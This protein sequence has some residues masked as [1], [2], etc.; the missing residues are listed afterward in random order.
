MKLYLI[1]LS[2]QGDF[3]GANL[4]QALKQKSSQLEF[5]G[6]G[7]PKMGLKKVIPYEKLHDT[8]YSTENEKKFLD[9]D[10]DVVQDILLQKPDVLITIGNWDF[11]KGLYEKLSHHK[12]LF[13]NLIKVHY[14]APRIF[15]HNN[16]IAAT[17][18][19]YID[20]LI[21]V[22][23]QE[24]SCFSTY[25]LPAVY[26]GHP[27]LES[28]VESRRDFETR[29]KYG[30]SPDAKVLTAIL[31]SNEKDVKRMLPF[32][33]SAAKN[34]QEIRKDAVCVM[35][36]SS[37]VYTYVDEMIKKSNSQILL[38]DEEKEMDSI[39]S[40]TD[41]G[42]ASSEGA[43]LKFSI[44]E[45]PHVVAYK[46]GFLSKVLLSKPRNFHFLNLTNEILERKVIP[47]YLDDNFNEN[48]IHKV[49]MKLIEKGELYQKQKEGFV[50]LKDILANGKKKSS[51][52]AGEAILNFVRSRA[53]VDGVNC[54]YI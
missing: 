37:N 30:I 12:K 32:F 21:S 45:V 52:N 29:R 24:V 31:G 9:K 54:I 20:F 39:L 13:K 26:V 44:A 48:N 18:G 6:I 4:K 43:T 38:L 8:I 53:C 36:V 23:P 15:Y 19:K 10:F 25:R 35:L 2:K 49:M 40:I 28:S 50:E 42:V 14:V 17:M 3:I 16:K 33:I 41:A 7:G 27:I 47:V 51:E 34:T 5:Y 11:C 22:Y 1:A 46:E